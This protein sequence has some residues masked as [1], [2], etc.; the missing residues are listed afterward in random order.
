MDLFKASDTINDEL[1]LAKLKAF[2][3]STNALNF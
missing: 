2:G 1:M 3:F